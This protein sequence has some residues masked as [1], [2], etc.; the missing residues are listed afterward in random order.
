VT[1]GS[2]KV[3]E[4]YKGKWPYFTRLNI[5]APQADKKSR[6]SD[7]ARDVRVA[8]GCTISEKREDVI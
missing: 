6:F 7:E 1:G 8:E 4:D 5:A 3:E 2:E